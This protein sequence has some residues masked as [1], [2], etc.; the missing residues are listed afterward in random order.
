[1]G[2]TGLHAS[3]TNQGGNCGHRS[4]CRHAPSRNRGACFAY[5]IGGPREINRFARLSISIQ[6]FILIF[7]GEVVKVVVVWFIIYKIIY[8]INHTV[9]I[10]TSSPTKIRM[11]D[12]IEMERRVKLSGSSDTTCKTCT[13]YRLAV[14]R[15]P[16][17]QRQIY[18]GMGR[19][20][21]YLIL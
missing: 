3:P 8:I 12:R 6:S 1:M 10:L 9:T 15:G 19:F 7:V 17:I 11:K 4:G 21:R 13:L 5:G 20:A 14:E 2:H 16:S 18:G